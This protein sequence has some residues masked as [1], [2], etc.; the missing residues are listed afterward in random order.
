MTIKRHQETTL[1]PRKKP[2][3][4]RSAATV[5]AIVE[6]AA[7]ILERDGLSGYNTNAI[8]E[9][10]GVSIG[11][12]YQY[13]PTKE[14]ITRALIERETGLL[15][16]NLQ[17]LPHEESADKVLEAMIHAAIQQQ[18][19]RPKLARLLDLEESHL[20]PN[21]E[22]RQAAE[23]VI[24]LFENALQPFSMENANRKTAAAD[25][26]AIVKALVDAAGQRQETNTD[27][28]FKRI[29]NTVWGYLSD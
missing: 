1:N 16:E 15:M 25:I 18:F 8:A 12:L 17:A 9:R 20:P 7:H 28:L 19:L 6:A 21:H 29:R 2:L 5:T 24:E 23:S 3:Q 13:F 10:A 14:A 11:S 22:V 4:K 26:L 27:A